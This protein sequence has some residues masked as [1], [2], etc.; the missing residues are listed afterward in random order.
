MGPQI[1]YIPAARAAAIPPIT[2]QFFMT[3]YLKEKRLYCHSVSQQVGTQ[4]LAGEGH[5]VKITY[6][7]ASLKPKVLSICNNVSW[8]SGCLSTK[9]GNWGL[10]GNPGSPLHHSTLLIQAGP[11]TCTQSSA[12]PIRL[13]RSPC[14][15]QE[16]CRPPGVHRA[17]GD[18]TSGPHTCCLCN[19][20]LNTGTISPGSPYLFIYLFTYFFDTEFPSII[21]T[22]LEL[23][24]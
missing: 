23:T 21:Q 17:S 20:H 15:V 8:R 19:R 6:Q 2:P 13:P 12:W 1:T 9:M 16:V 7:P 10:W 22:S 11:L 18:L 24:L 3:L 14:P 5:C 4:T